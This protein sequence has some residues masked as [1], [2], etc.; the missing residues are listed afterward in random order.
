[1]GSKFEV[2]ASKDKTC[3]PAIRDGLLARLEVLVGWKADPWYRTC[4]GWGRQFSA[5]AISAA[6]RRTA[7]GTRAALAGTYEHYLV[8][9]RTGWCRQ[10]RRPDQYSAL[11]EP[12]IDPADVSIAASRLPEQ[13]PVI[14]ILVFYWCHSHFLHAWSNLLF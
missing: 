11:V 5:A 2:P 6:I 9:V 4:Y 3:Q 1:M 14:S 12:D 13:Y 8:I 7:A 10:N